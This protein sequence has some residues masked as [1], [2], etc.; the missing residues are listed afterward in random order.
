MDN[1]QDIVTVFNVVKI[2]IVAI[3]SFFI[4]IILT[5]IWLKFLKTNSLGKNIRE[6]AAFTTLRD[7]E[8]SVFSRLHKKKE[9]TPTMGGALI[10]FSVALLTV[11]FGLLSIAFD[12]LWSSLNFLSRSQTL[13]PLGALLLAAIVG[14]T[15]DLFGI[16]R[17][18]PKGGGL[19]MRHKLLLYL[20]VAAVCAWWFYFKL[21]FDSINIPFLG[22]LTIGWWFLPVSIFIIV[23]TS[24]S[25]NET[26][27][28]DG[29]A[30]GVFLTMFGALGVIAFIEA[31]IDLTA[32]IFA[33]M[34]SLV[35]FLW[36]NIYPAKFFMGDTG[37]MSLGVVLGVIAML[38]NSVLLLPFIGLVFVMESLSVIIQIAS[39]K[40]R[41]KK[42]FQS[43]P[44]HHHFEAKGWPET[45]VTMRFWVLS[46]IGAT[47]GLIIY[48]VDSKIPP[49]LNTFFR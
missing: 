6:E 13:L 2:L 24:F 4:T 18:G 44:I 25:A 35:G 45:Q 36:F 22:N 42:I 23:A 32:F 37:S 26:D 14:L 12:G 40:F 7:K 28:L 41:G 43:T 49:L 9:G 19:Q 8:Q 29:L 15:D 47:L 30:G 48:L 46:F 11:I 17:V 10:W 3:T 31:K 34:G 39:K 16:F 38:T 5:P 21:G 27:G 20:G 1:P 33:I